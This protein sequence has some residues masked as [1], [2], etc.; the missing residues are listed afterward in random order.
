LKLVLIRHGATAWSVSG[1]HTGRTDLALL[2]EGIEQAT[3]AVA[4]V[5]AVLGSEWETAKVMSS[6]LQRAHT[7]AGLIFGA[8]RVSVDENLLEMHYGDYEGLTSAEIRANRPGWDLWRDGNPNGE[9]TDQVGA[10]CDA[11][12]AAHVPSAIGSVGTIAVV[13][14]AHLL[15]ILA[16]RTL[17]LPAAQGRLFTLHTAATSVIEDVRG[18][19]CVSLWNL[20][21]EHSG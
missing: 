17:A 5:R 21:A 13:A 1:Q 6:P 2:P 3:R 20:S 14:H 19:R 11:F 18:N 7:T 4:N 10:R 16:A 15:R 9:T 8:D 12:L